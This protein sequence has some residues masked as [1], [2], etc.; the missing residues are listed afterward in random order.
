M[1]EFKTFGSK[2]IIENKYPGYEE[3]EMDFK[4]DP[5]SFYSVIYLCENGIPIQRIAVEPSPCSPEDHT[6]SRS[7]RWVLEWLNKA[8]EMK[9]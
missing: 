3:D 2:E 9:T 5:Y 6:F 7:L 1:K 8:L 4:C